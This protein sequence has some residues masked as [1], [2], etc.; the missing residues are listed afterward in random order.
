MPIVNALKLSPDGLLLNSFSR[1]YLCTHQLC[2]CPIYYVALWCNFWPGSQKCC[3]PSIIKACLLFPRLWDGWC[4]INNFLS[5]CRILFSPLIFVSTSVFP[6]TIPF[7]FGPIP[8]PFYFLL[9]FRFRFVFCF[10]FVSFRFKTSSPDGPRQPE[11]GGH[12]PRYEVN[13]I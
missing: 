5:S 13:D 8:V 4:V 11:L 3:L 7:D 2:F 1:V 10:G 6:W 9:L 12:G